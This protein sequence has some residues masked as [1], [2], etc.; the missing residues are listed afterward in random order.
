MQNGF[1]ESFNGLLRDECLNE[2]LFA[3]LRHARELIS[4]WHVDYYH[5]RPQTSLDGLTPWE[6]R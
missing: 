3:N 1:V 6:Y 2:Q 5:H 4:A